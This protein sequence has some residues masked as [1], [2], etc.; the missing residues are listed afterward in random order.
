MTYK[1]PSDSFLVSMYNQYWSHGRHVEEGRLKLFASYLVVLGIVIYSLYGRSVLDEKLNLRIML[2]AFEII[3]T[4]LFLLM[5]I[6]MEYVINMYIHSTD[7][8]LE[9]AN[10]DEGIFGKRHYSTPVRSISISRIFTILYLLCLCFFLNLLIFELNP[11]FL[12]N[13]I[14]LTSI[15]WLFLSVLIYQDR[16]LK[17]TRVPQ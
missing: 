6:K 4:I 1:D 9:A 8:L 11:T 17:S 16:I 12:L 5:F 15:I 13:S 14:I 10:I 3:L 7:K 2:I